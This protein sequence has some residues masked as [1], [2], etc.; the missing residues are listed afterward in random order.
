MTLDH[1]V[2]NK[3]EA[4]LHK[5][6]QIEDFA[7][8][9][10]AVFYPA[11]RGIGHQIM[12]EEGYAWPSTLAIASDSHSDMYGGVGY[13]GTSAVRTHAA[14]IWAISNTW[15]Q[16]PPVCK[17]TF[18]G[19]LP[20]GVT[21]KDVIV[22]LCG[23]FSNDGVLN[24]AIEFA[25]SEVSL[26]SLAVDD[27]LAI[28]N[29]TT[30]WG[31]LTQPFSYW[32]DPARMAEA[33]MCN[34]SPGSTSQPKFNHQRLDDLFANQLAADHGAKYSEFLH[35]DLSTLAPHVSGP[36]SVKTATPLHDL[37]ARNIKID[38]ADW[39]SR[40]WGSRQRAS[41]RYFKGRMGSTDAK[42]YLASPEFVAA[43]AL[44]G[45]TAGLG[46]YAQPKGW[47]G[48]IRWGGGGAREEGGMIT[49]EEASEKVIATRQEALEKVV[50]QLD[51]MVE[52]AEQD[53]LGSK[54]TSLKLRSP[55]ENLAWFPRT[56]RRSDY[57]LRYRQYEHGRNIPW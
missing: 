53:I 21:G 24:H 47:S 6:R 44:H 17:V 10:G 54:V 36:N 35:L 29:T 40:P 18:T 37:V 45:R 11:G 14:S 34:E 5:Y 1:H 49:K 55:N 12:V 27:R 31:A 8:K 25:G 7:K 9:Q 38:K 57:L 15:W 43:S 13:L 39:P 52:E 3:N 41:N 26:K 56:L 42:A 32:R 33:A 2:Q 19:T 16:I 22:A 30:E 46:R 48:V 28:A 51:G 20:K 23:L 50:T 4:N